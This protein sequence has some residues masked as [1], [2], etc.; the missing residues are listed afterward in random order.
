MNEQRLLVNHITLAGFSTSS[1]DIA[2]GYFTVLS[3]GA[4]GVVLLFRGNSVLILGYIGD[5]RGN[6]VYIYIYMNI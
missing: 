2:P 5:D 4:E 3:L 1:F 6:D